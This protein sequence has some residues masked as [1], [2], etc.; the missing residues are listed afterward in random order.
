MAHLVIEEV[1]ILAEK[2]LP[3]VWVFIFSR[4]VT[5]CFSYSMNF[6][7]DL[8]QMKIKESNI[9]LNKKILKRKEDVCR[10]LNSGDSPEKR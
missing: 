5:L 4:V 9:T 6:T 3:E 10:H 1:D 7:M 8:Y 2:F